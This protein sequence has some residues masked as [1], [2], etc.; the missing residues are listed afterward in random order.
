MRLLAHIA[1]LLPNSYCPTARCPLAPILRSAANAQ[2]VRTAPP[3]H[4]RLWTTYSGH[5]A[6][7]P[8][9]RRQS[10]FKP[11]G[12]RRRRH[13]VRQVGRHQ[14]LRYAINVADGTK[15]WSFAAGQKSLSVCSSPA[16][17]GDS[18]TVHAGSGDDNLYAINAVD[19]TNGGATQPATACIPQR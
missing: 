7:E 18:A 15:R 5:Q 14:P 10:V 8:R 12:E 13:G 4:A 1:I 9:N 3:G 6:V 17:S 19:G 11:G 16:V 2:C